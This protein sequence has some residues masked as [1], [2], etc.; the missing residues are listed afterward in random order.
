[1]DDERQ[2]KDLDF[3]SMLS[4]K[5]VKMR[6]NLLNCLTDLYGP[7]DEKFTFGYGESF[8]MYT[9]D[10]EIINGLKDEGTT[11]LLY[12]NIIPDVIP[13]EYK[14]NSTW[15]FIGIREMIRIME[16]EGPTTQKLC[17]FPISNN[18]I[19]TTKGGCAHVVLFTS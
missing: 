7:V 18:F 17:P 8:T 14:V 13:K 15:R 6:K 3:E 11:I 12:G 16:D 19:P 2:I 9:Y 10:A 5:P 1:L 4:L